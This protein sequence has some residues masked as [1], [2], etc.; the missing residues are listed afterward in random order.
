MPLASR[1]NNDDEMLERMETDLASKCSA[2]MTAA[3]VM[4]NVHGVFSIDDLEDKTEGD[5]CNKIAVGVGYAGAENR[6]EERPGRQGSAGG[7]HAVAMM[8]AL[9]HVLLVVPVGEDC[10][11]RYDATKLLTVLR[12]RVHGTKVDGDSS[13]RLWTWV[14]ELPNIEQ[15][16][17]TLL[18][19][20][21]V[22]R[23]SMPM[24][25]S[26]VAVTP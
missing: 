25:G 6:L 1:L 23:V 15:S 2:A 26:T 8:D 10:T 20:S 18:Y 12:R 11:E 3:G 17:D 13:S 7:G 22:W 24:M 5:L 4:A 21:Q 14:K 19:Y 16:S 9:F